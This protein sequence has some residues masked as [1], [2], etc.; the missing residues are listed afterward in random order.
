MKS[1][2]L[3][4][5][6]PV[7]LLS[8]LLQE[9]RAPKPVLSVS[10]AVYESQIAKGQTAPTAV[11]QVQNT[12]NG[13]LRW[14]V[15][16]LG[17]PWAKASPMSGTNTG[18]VSVTFAT[19]SLPPGDYSTALLV[20]S[21]G[22]ETPA[23]GLPITIHILD[24]PPDPPTEICGDG[25]D[26]DKDGQIDEDCPP[27]PSSARG[28]QASIVCPPSAVLITAPAD[29]QTVINQNPA[30]STYCLSGTFILTAPIRPKATDTLIGQYGATLNGANV[31]QSYDQG[32][33]AVVSGWNCGA[34]ADV[35]IRNLYIYG[36]DTIS[37]VGGAGLNAGGWTLENNYIGN[38]RWGV[39]QNNP[40][41]VPAENQVYVRG[42]KVR[43]NVLENNK[44]PG[45]TGS[46][47]SGAYGIQNAD[48]PLFENNELKGNGAQPKF[49]ATRRGVFRGNYLHRNGVGIW[50]DGDN[51]DGLI[52]GNTIEDNCAEGIFYEIS[53]RGTIR[54]NTVNRNGHDCQ[55]SGIF[56]STSWAVEVSGNRLDGNFR[57]INLFVNCGSVGPAGH[58]YEAQKIPFDLRDV[59]VRDNQI[60][61]GTPEFQVWG[62]SF[63]TWSGCTAEEVALY[64][65]PSS[66]NLR[67]EANRYTVPSTTGSWWYWNG[68]KTWAAWQALGHDAAGSV[69]TR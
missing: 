38:C 41:T 46:D 34:C 16:P 49:T 57:A 27:P 15:S 21:N 36:R 22:G 51:V 45:A 53:A 12:G 62:S 24:A 5:F 69:S 1:A 33:I 67:F 30:G 40:W 63:A 29:I 64:S 4:V 61:V 65:N 42:W 11:F 55:G 2:F 31:Q 20:K 44:W 32:G 17:V 8:A 39:N 18:A 6:V 14:T 23:P 60:A 52:E 7:A 13:P 48:D 3:L 50:Y 66:K 28:P 58:N 43:G 9:P 59:L 26:N 47:G 54:G 10:P 56:I 25:V 19:A 35:T 37:C 68:F